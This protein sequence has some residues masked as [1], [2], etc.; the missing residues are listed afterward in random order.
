MDGGG[1]KSNLRFFL[2]I[3]NV[4]W[5]P[6][7]DY[8]P[9]KYLFRRLYRGEGVGGPPLIV[10]SAQTEERPKVEQRERGLELL[11]CYILQGKE[12][13]STRAG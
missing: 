5:R 10:N 7:A 13:S 8:L 4:P 6:A 1:E 3:L 2:A 12:V 11:P 9:S